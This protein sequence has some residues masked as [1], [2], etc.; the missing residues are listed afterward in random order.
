MYY[1]EGKVIKL[2]LEG[3]YELVEHPGAAACLIKIKDK[4]ILVKQY[5]KALNKFTLEIPAGK[6]DKN[7]LNP[8]HSIVREVKEEVG[9]EVN[10]Q[11][12]IFLG[13]IYTTP[14]FCN[15]VIY[16][17]YTHLDITPTDLKPMDNQEI[18]EIKLL[19]K[20]ELID[21]L[22]TNQIEDS[23][24]LSAICLALIKGLI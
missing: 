14:G 23:K 21:L 4:F 18:T 3:G 10:Q 17:Y 11:D 1:F 24:T 2:R 8:I 7:D 22:T 6:I 13:K 9:L 20:E 16:L 15:E 19:T 5:R 12:L